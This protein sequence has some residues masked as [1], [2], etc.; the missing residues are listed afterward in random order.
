MNLLNKYLILLEIIINTMHNNKYVWVHLRTQEHIY[1]HVRHD[2]TYMPSETQAFI[3]TQ[4]TRTAPTCFSLLS[5]LSSA[6]LLVGCTPSA[7]ACPEANP[8]P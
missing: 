4:H 3:G 6:L 2:Y 7:W 5:A 8:S 1:M